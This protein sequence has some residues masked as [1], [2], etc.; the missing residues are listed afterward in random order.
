MPD[1]ST[2]KKI[3]EIL[4]GNACEDTHAAIDEPVKRYGS[5]HRRF[6][7]DPLSAFLIGISKDGY[8]GA[9]SGLIHI[10]TDRYVDSKI[11]KDTVNY[12]LK[13][14]EYLRIHKK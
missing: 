3:S 12:S 8:K 2:H 7:H 11:K 9:I 6:Y 5:G 14:I 13:I 10:T 4:L 1:R